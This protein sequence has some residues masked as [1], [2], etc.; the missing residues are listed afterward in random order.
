[1]YNLLKQYRRQLLAVAAAFLM[2]AFLLP[3]Q[4]LGG[5]D[6]RIGKIYGKA[7]Y[8]SEVQRATFH[9]NLL[10]QKIFTQS[11]FGLMPV[12]YELGQFAVDEMEQHSELFALLVAE[13]RRHG[14]YVSDEML[15][16]KHQSLIIAPDIDMA[17]PVAATNVNNAL[18]DLMMVQQIFDRALSAIRISKPMLD[19]EIATRMQQVKM[20][21]V[22]FRSADFLSQVPQPTAQQLEEQFN[23]YKDVLP[24]TAGTATEDN[25][26]GFGYRY[27]DRAQIQYVAVPLEEV[28]RAVEASKPADRWRVDARRHYI[29]N[30]HLYSTTT[31][32]EGTTQPT[33]TTRPFEEVAQDALEAVIAPE[34][35]RQQAAIISR[36]NQILTVDWNTF[37][38]AKQGEVAQTSLGVP[39]DS[40]EYLQKLSERIE[41]QFKVK[42]T[43]GA[44]G[45]LLGANEFGQLGRI[46]EASTGAGVPFSMY[47]T[48]TEQRRKD[49]LRFMPGLPQV[50]EL[51]QFSQTLRDEDSNI[52]IFRRTAFEPE[53]SPA[54]LDEVRAKVE[55]DVKTKL[56]FELARQAAEQFVSAARER[57]LMTA[58]EEAKKQ[59]ID[60][61]LIS[62]QLGIVFGLHLSDAA[63]DVFLGRAMEQLLSLRAQGQEQPIAAIPLEQDGRVIVARLDDVK[64]DWTSNQTAMLSS[65]VDMSVMQRMNM[66]MQ[67][68]WFSFANVKERVRY[69]P[70]E[71]QAPEEPTQ[72]QPPR[73][74]LGI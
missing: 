58:A 8:A 63:T 30:P 11:Q 51:W 23:K 28:R 49:A 22:D 56:A 12:S 42:I 9:W 73:T 64:A 57:G 3:M 16:D 33:S 19:F 13:A 62:R 47:A 66:P 29:R 10:I 70:D 74:P 34:V 48:L 31:Q 41:E 27:P 38:A 45:T 39:F 36:I 14:A 17:D 21:A 68:Q 46:A 25:P 1:M 40:Y 15:R 20:A 69:E 60:T 72:P 32:S 7:F 61:G 52:Y 18:R 71:I 55:S 43:L 67:Q 6:Y 24:A 44:S 59:V 65:L 26:F 2:V 4:N 5:R 50:P 35:E 37:R 53:H 54:S